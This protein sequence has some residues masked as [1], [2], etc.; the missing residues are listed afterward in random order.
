LIGELKT[1]TPIILS[2][3]LKPD[4]VL[5]GIEAVSPIAVD[6]NSGV[7]IRPGVK[8]EDEVKEIMAILKDTKSNENPFQVF[9]WDKV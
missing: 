7:E 6:V 1:D 3:G 9:N 4:N 2:G 8:N 5:N